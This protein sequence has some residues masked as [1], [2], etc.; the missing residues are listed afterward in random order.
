MSDL[1][2]NPEVPVSHNEAHIMGKLIAHRRGLTYSLCR[3]HILTKLGP[4]VQSTVSL[5]R[6]LRR[7]LVKYL[8]TTLPNTLVFFVG[9]M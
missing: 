7:Q 8:L 2:G 3:T 5:T 6:L 4:V 1:V 9:K